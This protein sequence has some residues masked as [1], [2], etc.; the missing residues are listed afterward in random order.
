MMFQP[1]R[2]L[3]DPWIM[4][5][6]GRITSPEQWP[7]QAAF[8]RRLIQ[9]HMHGPWPG[10]PE[11]T[12]VISAKREKAL[13]GRAVRVSVLLNV[14]DDFEL[15]ASLIYPAH[16]SGYPV[17]TYN[18]APGRKASAAE[19]EAVVLQ[20]G[21]GIAVFDREM[22]RPDRP[23][24]AEE[25]KRYPALKCGTIMSWGWGHSI[26]ADWLLA[27]EDCGP[28]IC[29]GHSR[30][31]KAALAAGI[32]DDRFAVVAPMGSGCGG[33]GT[34]RFLG[35]ADGSRQDGA[36]CETIGA[37]TRRFPHW[38]GGDYARFGTDEKP[39]PIGREAEYFPL[40]SHMLRMAIAP[41]AVFSSDGMMDHWANP[42]GTQLAFQAA[43]PIFDFLGVPER[44]GFHFRQGGHAFCLEDWMALVDFCDLVLHRPRSMPRDGLNQPLFTIHPAEYAPWLEK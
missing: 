43:Q 21:C 41:R 8:F 28:L 2:Y 16:A 20:G 4:E 31:G 38:F 18:A 30:G 40:D 24:T 26:A 17:I 19:E 14:N 12:E 44:N 5:N 42:F 9:Q 13:D 3:P 34:A 39:Y 32:F 27:H 11:K 1:T 22:I 10:R 35:T 25:E 15:D 33:L 29:T 37:I 7:E 23:L 36:R 6:G